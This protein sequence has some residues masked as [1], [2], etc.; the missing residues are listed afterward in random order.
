VSLAGEW[1]FYPGE[2]LDAVGARTAVTTRLVPDL[3]RG[4][5][6][7]GAIASS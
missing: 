5:E 2:L 7:G 6:A 4:A 3:W 1:A